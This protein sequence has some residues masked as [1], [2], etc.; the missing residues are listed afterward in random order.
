MQINEIKEIIKGVAKLAKTVVYSGN[1]TDEVAKRNISEA[2]DIMREFVGDNF[3]DDN[4]ELLEE[5]FDKV[6][7]YVDYS[8][9]KVKYACAYFQPLLNQIYIMDDYLKEKTGT[10]YMI[11][12]IIHEYAHAI[13]SESSMNFVIEES[14]ANLFAE[15]CINHYIQK[16]KVI[17]SIPSKKLRKLRDYGYY[18]YDLS[19]MDEGVFARTMMFLSRVEGSEMDMM[20][21]YFF[22][23]RDK[24]IEQNVELYGNELKDIWENKLNKIE[25]IADGK[26][27]NR[28][29]YLPEATN[30]LGYML[31]NILTLNELRQY[32]REKK[33]DCIILKMMYWIQSILRKLIKKLK[34]IYVILQELGIIMILQKF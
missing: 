8:P 30:E 29:K 28:E 15:M 12:T 20:E 31:S 32:D 34:C 11:H 23:S 22:G 10:I 13:V 18:N 9:S 33:V 27:S 16:G 21:E 7:T 26:A 5:C 19:Y 4:L 17:K 2:K 14:F 6:P 3:G 24:F 1:I 25:R